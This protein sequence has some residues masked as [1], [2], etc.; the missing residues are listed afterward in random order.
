MNERARANADVND[1]TQVNERDRVNADV[2]G[3][4]NDVSDRVNDCEN[5]NENARDCLKDVSDR[6]NVNVRGRVNVNVRGC[7]DDPLT[8]A[9]AHQISP[10][11]SRSDPGGS[12]SVRNPSHPV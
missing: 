8:R 10:R 11:K 7:V 5:V 4:V 3:Y 9:D 1:Q 12:G 2:R 6:V